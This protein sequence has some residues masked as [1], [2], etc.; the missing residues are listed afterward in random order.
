MKKTILERKCIVIPKKN[1]DNLK[2]L[3]ERSKTLLGYTQ[4]KS[5]LSLSTD[6]IQTLNELNIAPFTNE[7]VK[8]YKRLKNLI[9]E[10]K[11]LSTCITNISIITMCL[12]AIIAFISLIIW[13]IISCFMSAQLFGYITLFFGII[14]LI[15]LTFLMASDTRFILTQWEPILIDNYNKSIP[16]SALQMACNIKEKYTSARFY[17]EELFIKYVSQKDCFLIVR[18]INGDDYYIEHWTNY[19]AVR[20]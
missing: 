8:K 7:S 20:R 4:L 17:V 5:D 14:S 9:E 15:N 16:E 11:N 1:N 6:L 3:A 19:D 12:S 18:D 2:E 10:M 13:G